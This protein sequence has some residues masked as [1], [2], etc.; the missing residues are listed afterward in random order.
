MIKNFA[1]INDLKHNPKIAVCGVNIHVV[2][3][4]LKKYG[5]KNYVKTDMHKDFDYAVLINRAISDHDNEGVKNQTCFQKF[6]SK[7]NL[8]ILSKNSIVLSKIIKY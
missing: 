4:Y 7:E 2:E 6:N 8:Y 1:K 5:I 3:F